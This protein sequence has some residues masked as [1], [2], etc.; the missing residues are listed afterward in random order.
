METPYLSKVVALVV[1]NFHTVSSIVAYE[2][3]HLIIDN[4]T[5][6]ELEIFRATELAEN[7]SHHIKYNNA[8]HLALDYNNPTPIVSSNTP[9]VL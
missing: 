1:E 8:H 7:I 3:L 5:V 6:R 9:R 4:Y 2:Y